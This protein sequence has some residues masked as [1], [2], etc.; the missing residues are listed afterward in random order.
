M[1]VYFF[2]LL[3]NNASDIS[4]NV[5]IICAQAP[6]ECMRAMRFT[7]CAP[8]G[9]VDDTLSGEIGRGLECKEMIIHRDMC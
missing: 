9:V 2:V 1:N 6:H 4:T 7:H 3:A 5:K 8:G